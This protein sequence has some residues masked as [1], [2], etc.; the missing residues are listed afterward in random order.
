MR[1]CHAQALSSNTVGY[2]KSEFHRFAIL[3]SKNYQNI[4]PPNTSLHL[5]NLPADVTEET[6]RMLFGQHGVVTQF[7]FFP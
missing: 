5:S 3:G 4:T 2:E 6:L 1:R 7:R